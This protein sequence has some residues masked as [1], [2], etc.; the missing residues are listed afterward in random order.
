MIWNSILIQ[1]Q[2]VWFLFLLAPW[3]EYEFEAL[4]K[5]WPSQK[6]LLGCL[7]HEKKSLTTYLF[8]NGSATRLDLL[9]GIS[10]AQLSNILF[11]LD[12][13]CS[14]LRLTEDEFEFA[15]AALLAAFQE[16]ENKN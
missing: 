16:N 14:D 2:I 5:P 15:K 11:E 7:S 3:I 10:K 1:I 8:D 6:A 13:A 4:N 9:H 12:E